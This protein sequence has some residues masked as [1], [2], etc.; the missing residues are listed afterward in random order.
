MKKKSINTILHFDS[1]GDMND[2]TDT[3]NFDD[4]LQK[5]IWNIGTHVSA[6]A[7]FCGKLNKSKILFKIYLRRNFIPQRYLHNSF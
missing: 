7:T 6:F 4:K 5:H 3:R 2:M 1:H